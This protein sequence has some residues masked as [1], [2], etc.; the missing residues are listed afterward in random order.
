MSAPQR[1]IVPFTWELSPGE[2][3]FECHDCGPLGMVVEADPSAQY[4]LVLRE[5]HF[6]DCPV[7]ALPKTATR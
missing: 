4:G 3:V 6:K 1:E 2:H 7:M 5:Q